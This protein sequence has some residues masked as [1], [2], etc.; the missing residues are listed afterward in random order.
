MD[1]QSTS[2]LPP[3]PPQATVKEQSYTAYTPGG[4]PS[5]PSLPRPVRP[6]TSPSLLIPGPRPTSTPATE[7]RTQS[8][9]RRVFASTPTHP[10]TLHQEITRFY[11]PIVKLRDKYYNLIFD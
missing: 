2:N 11:N 9:R 1:Q 3:L 7:A 10:R 8:I 4:S 6:E 5:E